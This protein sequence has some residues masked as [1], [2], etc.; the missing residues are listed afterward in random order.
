MALPQFVANDSPGLW[1]WVIFPKNFNAPHMMELAKLQAWTGVLPFLS[2]TFG[3]KIPS[4]TV[5]RSTELDRFLESLGQRRALHRGWRKAL[6]RMQA[7]LEDGRD[8]GARAT[9]AGGPRKPATGLR[10]REPI[11]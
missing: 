3:V 4:Y 7:I 2:S 11:T 10:V 6:R 1:G 8:R 9:I 5:V